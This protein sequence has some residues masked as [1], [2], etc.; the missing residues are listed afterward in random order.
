MENITI[1][2]NLLRS[3][4]NFDITTIGNNSL[5]NSTML[6]STMLS[7]HS[8][9]NVDIS[10]NEDLLHEIETLKNDLERAETEIDNLNLENIDLKKTIKKQ[11][12]SIDILKKLTSEIGQ[13]SKN[14]TPRRSTL[15][16]GFTNTRTSPL[17][18]HKSVLFNNRCSLRAAQNDTSINQQPQQIIKRLENITTLN[19]CVILS[20]SASLAKTVAYSN[21][22]MIKNLAQ[23]ESNCS[24]IKT[25]TQIVIIGDEQIKDLSQK[26]HISRQ[27]K[28]D[29]IYTINTIVKPGATCTQLLS[30]CNYLKDTLNKNDI[31]ILA[32]G[33]Q[34]NNPYL[35]F[36]ELGAAL[37]K[38]QNFRVYII[39]T[40]YNY[41]ELNVKH[42][43]YNLK[44]L[45]NQHPKCTYLDTYTSSNTFL[46]QRAKYLSYLCLKINT[47]I[48][49]LIY[50]EKYL[51]PQNIKKFIS[52]NIQRIEKQTSKP[53][54]KIFIQKTIPYYFE[55][56]NKKLLFRD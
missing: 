33:A 8:A 16:I 42:L 22:A 48:D 5:M 7:I 9:E 51:S 47:A 17:H 34:D 3:Q 45:I 50:K 52:Q 28:L 39:S 12:Q 46:Y 44:L 4:S 38:L 15:N 11:Q 43:N 19:D 18:F 29:D 41:F 13:K 20:P 37:H 21:T 55:K 35:L 56:I 2:R 54:S 40:Q 14:I 23:S 30:S 1:R 31:I 36:S 27:H 53:L 32:I 26:L 6:D 25:R 49:F 10:R 24:D